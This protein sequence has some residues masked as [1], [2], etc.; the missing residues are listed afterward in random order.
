MDNSAIVD[1]PVDNSCT[2]MCIT[3]WISS[4]HNVKKRDRATSAHG[5]R[6]R[7]LE[8]PKVAQIRSK[9]DKFVTLATPVGMACATRMRAHH[10]IYS[11]SLTLYFE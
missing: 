3:L 4:F 6:G 9:S 2:S 1:N 11:A 8:P 10:A 5:S 7:V